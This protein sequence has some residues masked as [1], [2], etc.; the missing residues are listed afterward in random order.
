VAEAYGDLAA[1]VAAILLHPEARSQTSTTNG[2]LREPL[3]KAPISSRSFGAVT[4]LLDSSISK[5]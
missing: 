2:A 1:T 4:V 3:I 5:I